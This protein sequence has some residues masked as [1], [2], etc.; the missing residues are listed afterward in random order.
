MAHDHAMP[1]SAG[2]PLRWSDFQ[3]AAP[4]AG[5]EVAKTAY[6]IYAASFRGLAE[7]CAMSDGRLAAEAQGHVD[8]EKATQRRY[9]AETVHGLR[10]QV[11]AGWEEQVHR[12]LTQEGS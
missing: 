12:W 5:E 11:Q 4:A 1:W 3:G 6:G 10:R 2:R 9:D 8:Q 7:P